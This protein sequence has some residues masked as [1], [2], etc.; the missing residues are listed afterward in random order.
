MEKVK[1][2]VMEKVSNKDRDPLLPKILY[3]FG[4]DCK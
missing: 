1:D 4:S 3:G 2:K